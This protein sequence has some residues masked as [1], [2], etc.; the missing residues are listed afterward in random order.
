M[1]LVLPAAAAP[2]APAAAAAAVI[3]PARGQRGHAHPA[4][5][6]LRR[7]EVGSA[8]HARRLMRRK[9]ALRHARPSG[10]RDPAATV[11][12]RTAEAAS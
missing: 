4:M 10:K 11:S 12:P 5:H 7:R 2:A 9:R 3:R 1:L 6:L 8:A